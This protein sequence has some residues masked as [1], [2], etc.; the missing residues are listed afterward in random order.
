VRISVII[1]T[2]HRIDHLLRC[3][4]SLS[5]GIQTLDAK[6]YEVIVTDDGLNPTAEKLVCSSY[7]WA[8]WVSGPKKGPAANR[9]NGARLATGDWLAFIDDDCEAS[10]AWLKAIVGAVS[11]F[12]VEVIEGKTVI[13]DKRDNPF[14]HG[15]ENLA[16]GN[17]WSC[18]LAL[19]SDVFR[20]L[21][22]FDED[23]LEAG[24]E[25]MEFAFRLKQRSLRSIFCPEALVFHPVRQVSWAVLCYRSFV[26]IRWL[27]LYRL[28]TSESLEEKSQLRAALQIAR[29]QALDL[30]RGTWHA[31]ARLNRSNWRTELFRQSWNWIT[32]PGALP[33]WVFWHYR[34]TRQLAHRR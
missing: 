16:G 1:P 6:Q 27:A 11:Q 31:A 28:K 18:N 8:R 15:V 24:G 4:Y 5:P 2:C 29:E 34:F 3:L 33:L 10:P 25:D 7:P 21:G 26:L 14:L 19:R 13:P 30:L 20:E 22:G 23:F 32:F 12:P 17:F 9:N